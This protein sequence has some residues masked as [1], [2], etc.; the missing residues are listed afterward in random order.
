M[1]SPY[2]IKGLSPFSTYEVKIA[3]VCGTDTSA[4]KSLKNITTPAAPKPV[5]VINFTDSV[6]NSKNHSAKF[7]D[8][9]ATNSTNATSYYWDFGNG[10]TD[11]SRHATA[12]YVFNK[13][14][15]VTL[16][17]S[18]GCGSD[19]ARV[20]VNVNIDLA[21]N[22]LGRSMELFPNPANDVVN[23]R[24]A[25]H[26]DGKARVRIMDVSGKELIALEE[27]N[28]NGQYRE[29]IDISSLAAGVYL[30]EVNDGE[31]RAAHKLIKPQ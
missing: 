11:S 31:Y 6:F 20:K 27:E 30:L 5:A 2:T 18:N 25:T 24:F 8:F 15:T 13:K 26:K 1:Q 9:N 21:E 7:F 23:L 17:V 10:Q 4:Y 28:I 12:S 3:N 14:Y 16:V 22:P 29:A 19:T